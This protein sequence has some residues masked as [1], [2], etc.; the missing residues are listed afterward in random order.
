M[1]KWIELCEA[2]VPEAKGKIAQSGGQLPFPVHFLET[3]LE[4][5][6]GKKPVPTTSPAEGI[7]LTAERFRQLKQQALLHDRDL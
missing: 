1:S 7:R 2:A 6:L 5:V 3:G 4:Q